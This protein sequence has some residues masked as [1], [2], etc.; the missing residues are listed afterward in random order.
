MK[1]ANANEYVTLPTSTYTQ[2]GVDLT[3]KYSI[4]EIAHYFVSP[5]PPTNS[6]IFILLFTDLILRL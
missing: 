6:I 4:N 1:S 3:N 2:V 5:V